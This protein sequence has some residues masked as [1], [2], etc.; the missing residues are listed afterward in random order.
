MYFMFQ[1]S[2]RY[3]SD[4]SHVI[5]PSEIE[6]RSDMTYEEEPIRILAREVKELRNKKIPLEKVLWNRHG[7]EEATWEPEDSMKQ[8]YPTVFN[9]MKI[10]KGEN[11]NSPIYTL[12]GTV[13]LGPQIIV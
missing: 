2:S 8:Q 13:V 5:A 10:P 7:I 6:I 11:C 1:C 12:V 4:L 3:Q 9:G